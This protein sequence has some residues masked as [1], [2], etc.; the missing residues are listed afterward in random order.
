MKKNFL[1]PASFFLFVFL[2]FFLFSSTGRDDAHITYWEARSL[3]KFGEILNYNGNRLEQSSSLLQVFMLSVLG[4]ITG[5]DIEFLGKPFSIVFGIISLIEVYKLSILIDRDIKY[6]VL[7]SVALSPY[8]VYWSFG[9]LETT[10]ATFTSLFL[11]ISFGNYLET[12]AV[13]K[14]VESLLV[15]SL[16]VLLFLTVRPENLIVMLFFL[17][18][19]VMIFVFE[20]YVVHKLDR[21]TLLTEW[22]KLSNLFLIALFLSLAILVFRIAYFGSS[23]PQPVLAKSDGISLSTIQEGWTYYKHTFSTSVA[24]ILVAVFYSI[25]LFYAF[26]ELFVASDNNVYSANIYIKISVAYTIVYMAFILFSGGDWMEGGRFFVPILPLTTISFLL[27]LRNFLRSRFAFFTGILLLCEVISLFEFGGKYSTGMP[28]WDRIVLSEKYSF[29]EYTWF[30]QRNRVNLRDMP[31]IFYM[32]E[33]INA[34]SLVKEEPVY[35]LSSQMGIVPYYVTPTFY[36][37]IYWYDTFS[38]AD[39]SFSQCSVTAGLPV[40]SNGM[41]VSYRYYFENKERIITLCQIP[42]PDVIYD[43]GSDNADIV[44]LNGYDIVFLQRGEVL[45]RSTLIQGDVPATQFIAIKSELLEIID[46]FPEVDILFSTECITGTC[47]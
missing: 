4:K 45:G 43:L 10:L 33:V 29:S 9:G 6:P 31:A 37:K 19:T 22:Y 42:E 15:S 8:F 41:H 47:F 12:Q 25:G 21:I 18:S 38:L 40:S 30:E 2:G 44:R 13:R 23:F 24:I 3:V 26:F 39:D 16:S 32:K 11:I 5:I 1:L 28:I 7:L 14:N 35:I 46:L 20:Y 27:A 34:I 36:K 17:L